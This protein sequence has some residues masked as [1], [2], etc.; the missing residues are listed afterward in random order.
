MSSAIDIDDFFG[1]QPCRTTDLP[2]PRPLLENLTRCVLEV[3]AGARD[4]EQ[5]A[6][7]VSDDV[8]RHL[9]R[10]TVLASRARS[11]S[12]HNGD[13]FSYHHRAP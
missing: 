9:L 6:R 4:L 10:R 5:L 3:L 7:W 2:D 8:Y 12:P 1:H 13:R 11:I